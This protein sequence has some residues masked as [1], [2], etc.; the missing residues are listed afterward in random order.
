MIPKIL[1]EMKDLD[2][3]D[4][5][6]IGVGIGDLDRVDIIREIGI[7]TAAKIIKTEERKQKSN[8]KNGVK[9]SQGKAHH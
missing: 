1:S 5:K 6:H 8:V 7:D 9:T 2:H 4:Q 3:S